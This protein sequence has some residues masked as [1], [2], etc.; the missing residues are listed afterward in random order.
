MDGLRPATTYRYRVLVNDEPWAGG[1]RYDWAAGNLGPAWRAPD[2]RLRTH[3]A[4]DDPDPVTFPAIGDFGVGVASGAA[5]RCQLAV[6]RTMQR[7]ADAVDIRFIVGL[8]DSICHG[9]AGPTDHSGDKD[10]W[11]AFFQ[12]YRYLID[13]LAFYPTVGNHDGSDQES[14]DDRQQLED[15]LFPRTRFEPRAEV[16]RASIDPRLCCRLQVGG[17]LQL[18]CVDTTW[19]AEQGLH[20]FNDPRQRDWLR[21]AFTGDDVPR[22]VPFCHHPAYRAGPHHSDLT[23]QIDARVPLYRS[24]DVRLMLHG[25]E[26]NFQHGC[27]D[28]LHHIVSGAGGELDEPAP[29]RFDEAATV[30]WAAQPHCL[31]VQVTADR[32]IIR[33]YRDTPR[34]GQPQPIPRQVPDGRGTDEPIVI[35]RD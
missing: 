26:H 25:H 29:S 28:G 30:S 4:T 34:G 20:W 10:W 11:L 6:A 33:P 21:Q 7:L 27:V 35:H 14:S 22:L 8:G 13:H 12:R 19:G 17:L 18:V 1:Q 24:A 16:G 32:L 9:P 3:A 31:L 5:G 15:N 2:E 23:E